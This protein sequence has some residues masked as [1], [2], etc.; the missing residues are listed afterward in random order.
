MKAFP[1][2]PFLTVFIASAKP[3]IGVALENGVSPGRKLEVTLEA[4]KDSP[5]YKEYEFKGDKDQFP[6]F[7]IREIK[8]GKVLAP[9]GWEGDA[10][11][12]ERPLRA[13]SSVLFLHL[14][15][16]ASGAMSAG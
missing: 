14:A 15:P 4:D 3:S 9:V 6:A 13:K 1:S 10:G 5:R 7:L 11:K 8:T 16:D 12:D 2:V